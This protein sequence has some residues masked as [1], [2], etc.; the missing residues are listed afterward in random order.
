MTPAIASPKP[1]APT[2]LIWFTIFAEEKPGQIVMDC[3]SWWGFDPESVLCVKVSIDR[4][5]AHDNNASFLLSA[6]NM[7]R[8]VV[9]N[10]IDINIYKRRDSE[11]KFLPPVTMI[12]VA[13]FNKIYNL[14]K[15]LYLRY[16][17][18]TSSFVN[19]HLSLMKIYLNWF[20]H[21]DNDRHFASWCVFTLSLFVQH[22]LNA[23]MQCMKVSKA[24]LEFVFFSVFGGV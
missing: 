11:T 22:F 1:R 24:C 3:Y 19:G 8:Y 5:N 12:V 2:K 7:C 21:D 6:Q 9:Q 10:Q 16:H 15:L 13:K 20:E 14:I 4:E 23:A 18:T 17:C